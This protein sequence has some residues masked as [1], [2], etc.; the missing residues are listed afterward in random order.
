MNMYKRLY[1]STGGKI[2]IEMTFCYLWKQRHE[3]GT[4]IT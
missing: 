3:N 1:E 2:Q 4:K